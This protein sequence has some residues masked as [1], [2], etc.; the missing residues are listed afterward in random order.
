MEYL[1]FNPNKME[2]RYGSGLTVYSEKLMDGRLVCTDYHAAGMPQQPGDRIAQF[3]VPSFS[4]EIDGRDAS[5][6]WSFADWQT[7][8]T[9]DA[10]PKAT[11]TLTH[12]TYALS[13]RIET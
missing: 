4:L 13:L 9:E 1:V 12:E 6:G 5:F 11:L 7:G 2:F 10:R 3:S 8:N